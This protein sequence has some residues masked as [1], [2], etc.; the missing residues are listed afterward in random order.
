[1]GAGSPRLIG[2]PGYEKAARFT[3]RAIGYTTCT[4]ALVG[5]AACAVYSGVK[6]RRAG[7]NR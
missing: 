5:M 4:T 1:M 6:S 3:S 7:E 2:E